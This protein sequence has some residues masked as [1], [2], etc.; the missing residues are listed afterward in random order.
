MG[1]CDRFV[2]PKTNVVRMS[3]FPNRPIRSM[4][5]QSQQDYLGAV[6]V[7]KLT[8]TFLQKCKEPRLSKENKAQAFILPDINSY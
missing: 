5:S 1:R 2:D 7:D 8:V 6:A 3:I 4:H